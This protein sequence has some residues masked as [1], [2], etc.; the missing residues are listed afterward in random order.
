V[1]CEQFEELI[2]EGWLDELEDGDRA[3]LEAHL[4]ECPVC[5]HLY[6][7]QV[8]ATGALVEAVAATNPRR[9]PT[10]VWS[11]IESEISADHPRIVARRQIKLGFPSW[12]VAAAVVLLL[13]FGASALWGLRQTSALAKERNLRSELERV[14]DQ[15]ELIMEIVDS[16]RTTKAMLRATQP[17]STAYGKLYTRSDMSSVV[18]LVGRLPA[19]PEGQAYQ[20]WLGAQGRLDLAG[21]IKVDGDGFG[22][23]VFDTG[24]Q[25]PVFDSAQVVLDAQGAS[26]PT[27]TS[28]AVIRWE[29]PR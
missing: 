13:L 24:R 5:R 7:S 20:V 10:R 19:P 9:A 8:T 2:T 28:V 27:S 21:A 29:A 12:R 4:A 18:V 6:Q 3:G 16:N 23:L 25:G 14:V 26:A 1:T 17:G 15:R 22:L 11:A